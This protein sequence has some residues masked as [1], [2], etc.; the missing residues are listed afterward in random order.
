MTMTSNPRIPFELSTDRSPIPAPEGRSI[1][2]HLVVNV[3]NWRFDSPMP[4]KIITAPH[5]KETVPDVP[6]FAWA[7]YG[8]RCGMPRIMDTL[9]AMGLQA[10]C[11]LNAGVIANYP[12]LADRI[13]ELDWEVIGHGLHQ[14]ALST[15]SSEAEVIGEAIA[16]LNQFTGQRLKGWLGPGLRQ[17]EHTPDILRRHGLRYCC[18]WVLDDLPVWMRTAHG[19]MIAMPYSLEINDSILHA[20]QHNP[21]DEMFTR[22]IE[23]LDTFARERAQG[24]R[25]LTMGLHPHLVA[26]PHR[27]GHF[28]RTLEMLAER[29]D[30]IFMTGSQIADW[31]EAHVPQP[32]V[33]QAELA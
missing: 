5:G 18:D 17:T 27:M 2:V 33:A 4:R 24:P 26:V 8:M 20:V 14:K 31:F 3:E 7:E 22:T 32:V 11:A 1:I 21:S 23:T 13:L 9:D 15:E 28:R 6:N 25:I 12:R 29:D 16:L 30:T 19:P 10:S